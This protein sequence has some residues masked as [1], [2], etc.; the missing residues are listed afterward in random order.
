MDQASPSGAPRR[1]SRPSASTIIPEFPHLEVGQL[2]ARIRA[3][4]D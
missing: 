2:V 1:L 3:W 4:Y